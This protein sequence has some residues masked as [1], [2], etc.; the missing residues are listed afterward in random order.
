MTPKKF[1]QQPLLIIFAL[2][3]GGY[4]LVQQ[5]SRPMLSDEPVVLKKANPPEIIMYST[6]SCKYC[7][8]AREFFKKHQLPYTEYDIEESDKNLQM[9]YML[10]GSG[11][12]LII[13]NREIIHGFNEAQMRDAL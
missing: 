7:Y 3:I 5:Y 13:I 2:F 4:L 12:P 9:F 10:G 11:T 8:V 1:Y 6:R